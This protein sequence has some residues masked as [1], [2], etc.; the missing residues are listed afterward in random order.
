[1]ND[2]VTIVGL[3]SA[4]S[5]SFGLFETSFLVLVQAFGFHSFELSHTGYYLTTLAI[6]SIPSPGRSDWPNW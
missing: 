3:V 6:S 1:M 4:N 5:L 2:Y